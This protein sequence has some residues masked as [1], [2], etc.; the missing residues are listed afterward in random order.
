MRGSVSVKTE[1][2]EEEEEEEVTRPNRTRKA[3]GNG[4]QHEKTTSEDGIVRFLLLTFSIFFKFLVS[5]D[6]HFLAKISDIW[7]YVQ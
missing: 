5:S 4:Q 2:E 7:K 1:E 6:F 3:G